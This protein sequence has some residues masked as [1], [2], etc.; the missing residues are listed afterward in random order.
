MLEKTLGDI[1]AYIDFLR[2]NGY[3][4][5]ISDFDSAF[6][7]CIATFTMYEQSAQP[8]ECIFLKDG[9][10][11]NCLCDTSRL[12][13]KNEHEE[14]TSCSCYSGTEKFVAP[15]K[16]GDKV[17]VYIHVA[18]CKARPFDSMMCALTAPLEYM[19]ERLYEEC[20]EFNA[21]N[22]VTDAYKK[23]LIYI[24]DH[25]MEGISV[26][27]VAKEIGYSV[28]YFGYIF[29][30]NRGISANK[31]INELQLAKATE[32]L[33]STSLAVSDIAEK[34]GFGDANYFSTAFKSQ[35]GMSPRQYRN[36]NKQ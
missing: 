28:S 8:S 25:Y 32:L 31:Y 16:H 35:Y 34:V 1:T 14:D 7:P 4:V 3:A 19:F 30:K 5:S 12:F 29:K 23:S 36:R 15:M 9:N 22:T 21:H 10:D 11:D 24:R 6:E 26:A 33:L 27:D 18:G 2:A 20:C 17:I 13:S